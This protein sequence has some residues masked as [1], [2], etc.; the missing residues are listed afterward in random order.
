M[1]DWGVP[2]R[3]LAWPSLR[4]TH[5]FS[6]A[7]SILAAL[8]TPAAVLAGALGAWRIGADPGWTTGF[9]ITNGLL[10]HWQAW[11]ALAVGVQ[12]SARRL[13]KWLETYNSR[14]PLGSLETGVPTREAEGGANNGAFSTH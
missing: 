2:S 14:A 1:L 8:L 10:S 12:V 13:S 5:S 7:L 9:F 11:F 4:A 3:N 6:A